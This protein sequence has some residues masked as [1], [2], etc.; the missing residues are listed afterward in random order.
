[1]KKLLLVILL[2]PVIAFAA[3]VSKSQA[4]SIGENFFNKSIQTNRAHNKKANLV[5][6]QHPR[7]K[8]VRMRSGNSYAPYYIFNNEEGGFV[9][10]SGDDCATPILGYSIEGNIDPNNLPIQLQE[11]LDAYAE[12]IQ[13][14]VE[15]NEQAIDSIKDLWNAYN[16]APQSINSTAAV[17]ALITTSWNQYPYYNDLCPM[18]VS[19]ANMGGH[20][21]TGCVATAMA[22]IMKYWEYPKKGYGSKSYKSE[23]Y[24]TLYA[25]FGST[26]YDWDDMPLKLSSSTSST[27]NNAVATLMYHC[28]VAVSMDY[29]SDG[30]GS[31][32][33]YVVDI[34]YGQ[35]SAQSALTDYFGYA[36]TV[37]GKKFDQSTTTV[38]WTNMLKTELNNKM[39]IIYAG[40]SFN[41]GGH[42]F[43]CDG[44]DNNDK[45]HFNWGWGG[46]AN[47]Y[48][49]LTA[50]TPEN[51][52]FSQG[53]QAVI[54]IKP[55]E[56]SAPAKNYD[57]Y[58]NTDLIAT[59]TS[60]STSSEPNAYY[61]GNTMSFTAK[62]ENN[63]TGAFNG[64]LK[65]AAFNDGG[66]FVAWSNESYH[67]SLNA[68]QNTVQKTYTFTGGMPFKP[69]KYR[70]YMYYQDD[71]ETQSKLVKTDEGIIFTEYNNIAFTIKSAGNLERVSDYY[72]YDQPFED[73]FITGSRM[74]IN[75]D[76]KN[77]SSSNFY[78]KIRLG[79]YNLD[80]T[81]AELI[82]D[83]DYS[84][85]GI[86]SNSTRNLQFYGI[87]DVDPGTYN[88]I[89]KVQ[90][91]NQSTWSYM[92]CSTTYP[93][94]ISFIVKAPALTV[95]IFE[96]NNTQ[97]EASNLLWD[98]DPEISDFETFSMCL[99]EDADIDYYK[100]VFPKSNKY[101]VSARLYDK[102]NRGGMFYENADA[103]Y[104][105]SI[106]GNS[107]SEYYKS[108][109]T[110]S[111][112]GPNILYIRVKPYE[113][114][115]LGYYELSGEID[116]V[117][118]PNIQ[119]VTCAQASQIAS[120][121]NHNSPTTETYNVTGFV[122]ETE[123][124]VSK[125]Q[126]VFW[127]AD[128]ENGGRVFQGYWCNVPEQIKVGDYISVKGE[129]LRYN[130]TSEIKHGDVLLLERKLTEGFDDIEVGISATKI[131]RD[132]QIFILRGNKT[133]T[134]TGQRVQ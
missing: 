48:F 128:T 19:L 4:R 9:I 24:G 99:H 106:G 70:A 8:K 18:D 80:G 121:L 60:S 109:K 31:S 34:G 123:G 53:Q 130:S 45:F 22:Q 51:Y 93:N 84:S 30:R 82:E 117:V 90:K 122:T 101:K 92:E 125:G 56:G 10:V 50:L 110:I 47:G 87:L 17:S 108:D 14:T 129:I 11:L 74:R 42:A 28:G 27:Q 40:F 25:D 98:I 126:Q 20:P 95:D 86:P 65:V 107:Y 55:K 89:L 112:D 54:G 36:S 127:M 6:L 131:F 85:S 76:V 94:P 5:S 12:E 52:N 38:Q 63:G 75:V 133:Y 21:T 97:S 16:R 103:Q 57:L 72:W 119:D 1:M 46:Q 3:P 23:Y 49:S 88:L 83:I 69:G 132:G 39:P 116:E 102:Y 67:F 26:A 61:F 13:L 81:L 120:G 124:I 44:Y 111:L 62:V 35:A 2:L 37:S 41:S 43:V 134:L 7:M 73:S 91:S 64:Y 66:D 68:G 71:D 115:G 32:S 33:A 96:P 78:G 118:N 29:N 79:L 100:L 104:A 77:N 15:N 113:M 59:N 105:Y 114:N 58:M